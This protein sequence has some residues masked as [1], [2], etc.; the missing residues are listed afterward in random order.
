M[1]LTVKTVPFSLGEMPRADHSHRPELPPQKRLQILDGAR[2][3]FAELGYERAS[4]DLIATRAGV[5]KATVY[6]H[7]EDKKALFFAAFSDE[8][9][10]V[11]DEL[12]RS[13]GEAGGDLRDALQ[14][15]GEKLVHVLVSPA[16]ISLYRHTSAETGRFPELGAT[17]FARGPEVVYGAVTAWLERWQARG[18]LRLDD[19]R[20]AAVQFVLLCQGDLVIRAQLGVDPSPADARVHD[21]VRRAVRTFLRAY[22]A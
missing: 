1:G 3:A 10:F 9:D 2:A 17:L 8:A 13:L 12:R 14:R 15:V 22:V 21:T 7:F 11:R 5:S 6:N 19:A 20:A 16:F 18:A 4:V